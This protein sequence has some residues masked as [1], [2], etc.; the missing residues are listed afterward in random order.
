MESF[1]AVVVEP[2]NQPLERKI[3]ELDSSQVE[4][5]SVFGTLLRG[6]VIGFAIFAVNII[7]V[8]NVDLGQESQSFL[9]AFTS[10]FSFA[11]VFD[12]SNRRHPRKWGKSIIISLLS[13]LIAFVVIFIFFGSV[14]TDMAREL[15]GLFHEG[16]PSNVI[17]SS[18]E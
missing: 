16:E 9:T 14:T 1:G 8:V 10:V 6:T 5:K 12:I 4:K 13:G 3:M 18:G 2:P 7:I 11:I 15:D 17:E